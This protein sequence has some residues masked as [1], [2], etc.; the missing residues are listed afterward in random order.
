MW[1][2]L[3]PKE[4]VS[5]QLLALCFYAPPPPEQARSRCFDIRVV[6]LLLVC[7][8]GSPPAYHLARGFGSGVNSWLV[9][10]EVSCS[11]FMHLW[12]HDNVQLTPTTN[13]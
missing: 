4:Q 13:Y 9:H 6:L 8:D 5:P 3:P 2:A 12:C 7:L 11:W 1:K 10:F